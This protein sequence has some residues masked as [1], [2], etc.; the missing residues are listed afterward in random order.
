M[1][2]SEDAKKEFY[3]NRVPEVRYHVRS[4]G[5]GAENIEQRERSSAPLMNSLMY[6]VIRVF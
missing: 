2:D 3:K 6:R 5:S 1:W 4:R